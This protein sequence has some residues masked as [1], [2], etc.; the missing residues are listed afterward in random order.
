MLSR[1]NAMDSKPSSTPTLSDPIYIDFPV[2]PDDAKHDDGTPLLNRHSSHIT[3]GH[4]FPGARVRPT[5]LKA[6]L[7]DPNLV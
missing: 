4:D 5:A 1:E 6:I 3:R 2:L 7:A